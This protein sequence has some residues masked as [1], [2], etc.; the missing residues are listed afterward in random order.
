M[1]KLFMIEKNC[2]KKDCIKKKKGI[3]NN[4]WAF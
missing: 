2:K 3:N 4:G 1:S